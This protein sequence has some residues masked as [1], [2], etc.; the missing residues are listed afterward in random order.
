[1]LATTY[2]TEA[3]PN[4]NPGHPLLPAPNGMNSKSWPLKSTG[5][6]SNLSGRNSSGLSHT[7]VGIKF[8]N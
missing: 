3:T 6:P 5:L 4:V 2:S 8:T 1:M 7:F